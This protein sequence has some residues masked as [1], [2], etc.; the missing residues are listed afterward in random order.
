M[1]RIKL[2]LAPRLEVQ[3]A[4]REL[5]LKRMEE[6]AREGVVDVQLVYGPEGCG[7]TAWLRQSVALLKE[8]GFDVIYLNPL[9]REI[10]AEVGVGD[11]KRRIAE[12]LREATDEAWARVAWAT[13]DLAKELIRTGRRKIAVLADDVF[14][15]IGL[16]KAAAYVKGLLGLIEYPPRSVDVVVAVVATS[17][18]LTR[19]EI[20]RHR[21]AS[22]RPIW[23]MPRDGFIQLYGQI[24]GEKPLFE[25]VWRATGGNPKLLGELYK[26][27]WSAE[28]ALREIADE[29]R[30]TAFVKTLRDEE[31]ELLRR[32]VDDPDV[33]Y[34]REG[35]PLMERL[36]DLN[37]IVDTLPERDPWFWAGEPPP[38]RDPELGIG[39][40]IAWQT[41][42]HREAVRRAL[43]G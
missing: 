36:A 29:R 20:G 17:E 4:D 35:I 24:P 43:G 42:L 10:A 1:E 38:E 15:A 8:L 9:E 11:V 27:G 14:Q 12:I 39:R 2:R 30:I 21:W 7:K 22:H 33:L 41:P 16:H 28:K 5:A 25:E 31:R 3:F 37:L 6:W 26:A 40:H 32:A 13:V 23:N 18:G 34:T 19:R